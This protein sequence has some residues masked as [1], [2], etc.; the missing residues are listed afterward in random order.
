MAKE[1]LC[2]RKK[3]KKVYHLSYSTKHKGTIEQ[4]RDKN[5][6]FYILIAR[7]CFCIV[8]SATLEILINQA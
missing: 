4:I 8:M 6:K 1:F 3:K 5:H 2:L 7:A